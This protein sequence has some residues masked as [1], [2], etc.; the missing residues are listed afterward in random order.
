MGQQLYFE[1]YSPV[2]DILVLAICII[3]I[4]LV[5]TSYVA[6]SKRFSM[7]I[8]MIFYLAL[9][10]VCDL[11]HHVLYSRVTNG[12][13]TPVYVVRVMY[14]AVLF[15]LFL[16]FIVYIVETMRLERHK[17]LPTMIISTT[18]YFAVIIID[19][20]MTVR[21]KG[22]RLSKNGDHVSGYNI[23]MIGYLMFIAIIIYLV[24]RFKNRIY[25]KAM[26]GFYGTMIVSFVVLFNQGRHGQSSYTVATFLF[27]VIAMMYLMHSNPYD[28]ELGAVNVMALKDMV[29]H[30]YRRKQ[31][32]FLMS[33]Y[34]PDFD[35]DSKEFPRELQRT[36]RKYSSEYFKQAV[37]FQ[38]SNGH[39]VLLAGKK[40]NPHYVHQL[41]LLMQQFNEEYKRFNFDYKVLVGDSVEEISAKNE[42]LNVINILHR[43]LKMNTFH[44]VDEEDVERY[45]RY[46][47]IVEQIGDICRNHDLRDPR[48]L[49]YCQPV[50]NI[51][52]NR[53]DTAEALMRLNLEKTGIVYPDQFIQIAE[54]HGFIHVLTEIILQKTCDAIKVLLEEGYNVNR[55]SV[56]VSAL[57]LRDDVFAS[58]VEG[59]INESG[60]PDGKIAIEITE[61]Q[62]ESDFRLVKNRIEELKG[63]GV[64][65][66]LDDFGTG[67][68][69][70]ERILELPFDIIKFDRSLVLASDSDAR[71]QKMVANLASMFDE[72]DYSV[73]YEGVENEKD[74]KRCINMSASYLQG[75]K[76][77]RPI[78]IEEL[79]RFF[80][81]LD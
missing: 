52:E 61:S 27:P 50:F 68:S 9:A 54:E 36:I 70:M 77:S 34:L 37:L 63:R 78:P 1:N 8:N 40:A 47:Y 22:F 33:L 4:I 48:V 12:N 60:L 35:S 44:R 74:E 39:V 64:M 62:T 73:L 49:V 11:V 10:A 46:T 26:N 14:H 3:M 17:R 72:L 5:A 56:N 42:Y 15:S 16:L 23:F 59:I 20:V 65:F 18:V 30:Y 55:I 43:N 7:F 32:F 75:Y 57:E 38:I 51:R 58:D 45:K 69:N 81:K 6:R 24:L 67:Y 71:S 13:Y 41:N 28:I 79:K 21:E 25:R 29:D 2:G 66:Y 80:T 53:Y 31:D 19:I 76:Y